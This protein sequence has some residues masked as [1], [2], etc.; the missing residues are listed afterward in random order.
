MQKETEEPR[1]GGSVLKLMVPDFGYH[2]EV[3]L[4]EALLSATFE[5]STRPFFYNNL[6][7]RDVFVEPGELSRRGAGRGSGVVK[8]FSQAFMNP[9]ATLRISMGELMKEAQPRAVSLD[10]GMAVSK[11]FLINET[12]SLLVGDMTTAVDC[13]REPNWMEGWAV[14]RS[15]KLPKWT[16][17]L[18]FALQDHPSVMEAAWIGLKRGGVTRNVVLLK[19]EGDEWWEEA[20]RDVWVF[21]QTTDNPCENPAVGKV[22]EFPRGATV[23]YKKGT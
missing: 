5:D 9:R 3:D 10:S 16:R 12:C 20:G 14:A 13:A 17:S 8:A 11:S 2:G 23:F 1:N 4:A 18:G 21:L 19:G 6:L 7:A 15:K 22:A